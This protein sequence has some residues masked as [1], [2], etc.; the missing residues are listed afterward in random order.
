M[1][2]KKLYKS[3][4]DKKVCGVCGGIAEYFAIDATLVR[5]V[6]AVMICFWGCGLVLYIIAACVMPV[7]G[8]YSQ[9]EPQ[10]PHSRP[11]AA[12][13]QQPQQ[14][15]AAPQQPVEPWDMPTDKNE[16]GTL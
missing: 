10:P 2:G 14:Q 4:T 13:Y 6:F 11:E 1:N 12:S 7:A 8:G 5:L 16:P 9:Q 15:P 3:E